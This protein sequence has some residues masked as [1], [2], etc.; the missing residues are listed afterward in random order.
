MRLLLA[1]D[2]GLAVQ[3]RPRFWRRLGM[4]AEDAAKGTKEAQQLVEGLQ[5]RLGITAEVMRIMAASP[6]AFDAYLGL[7]VALTRG[8]LDAEFRQQI[9]S[10][11]EQ[12]AACQCWHAPEK[13]S[14]ERVGGERPSGRSSPSARETA[15]LTF[16][17]QC[18]ISQGHVPYEAVE[19]VRYAGYNDAEISE[20]V[21]NVALSIFSNCLNHIAAPGTL[22]PQLPQERVKRISHEE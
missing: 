6:A 2:S 5:K 21:A 8:A 16:A 10:A 19:R 7:K 18:L 20:I 3:S 14:R 1:D 13:A 17:V 9:L 22:E 11:V 15:G 12:S 4:R